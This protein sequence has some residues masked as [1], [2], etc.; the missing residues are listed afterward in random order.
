M[1]FP[2]AKEALVVS[3]GQ[4]DLAETKGAPLETPRGHKTEGRE[5]PGKGGK[6][7][8]NTGRTIEWSNNKKGGSNR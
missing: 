6:G 2:Q 4:G 3:V 5:I 1:G 8:K 7:G